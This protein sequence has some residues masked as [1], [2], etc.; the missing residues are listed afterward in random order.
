MSLDRALLP[1]DKI[2]HLEDQGLTFFTRK[3]KW[4]TAGPCF[5]HGGSD[6]IRINRET[7][8]G[9]CMACGVKWG[10]LIAFHMQRYLPTMER[11][12]QRSERSCKGLVIRTQWNSLRGERAGS[13]TKSRQAVGACTL[14]P[15]HRKGQSA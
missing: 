2:G 6:S 1:D 12:E 15:A 9:V 3:G 8:G 7:G 14:E 4:L 13:S 10:D 11:L 5:D